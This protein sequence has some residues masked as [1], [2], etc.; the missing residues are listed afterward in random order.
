MQKQGTNGV[1]RPPIRGSLLLSLA[2]ALCIV[3]PAHS[4]DRDLRLLFYGSMSDECRRAL[5]SEN[6]TALDE[7]RCAPYIESRSQ[8]PAGVLGEPGRFYSAFVRAN[9]ENHSLAVLSAAA[10][11]ATAAGQ[12]YLATL[13]FRADEAS[14]RAP[15]E[16]IAR[17]PFNVFYQ[18]GC[19]I[20]GE[21]RSAGEIASSVL[22]GS[23]PS[24][25]KP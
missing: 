23:P 2:L 20:P 11:G 14:G 8:G 9:G 10:E 6:A 15:L 19:I 13:M 25:L 16:R 5:S 22:R 24:G 21:E 17:E 12:V 7:V 3:S 18:H 1:V 4:D